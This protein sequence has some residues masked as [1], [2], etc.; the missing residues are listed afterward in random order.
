MPL[1][2]LNSPTNSLPAGADPVTVTPSGTAD[3]Y[4][5]WVEIT[6][7]APSDLFIAGIVFR[8]PTA[9]NITTYVDVQIGKGAAGSETVVATFGVYTRELFAIIP[10]PRLGQ[11]LAGAPISGIS[12]GDRIAARCRLKSTSVTTFQVAVLTL[13]NPITGTL[14][15]TANPLKVVPDG[16]SLSYTC[17]ATPWADSAWQQITASTAAAWIVNHLTCHSDAAGEV[18]IQLGTGASGS[19]TPVYTLRTRIDSLYDY[20]SLE[21]LPILFDNIASGARVAFRCRSS[22]ASHALDGIRVGYY[23][24]PL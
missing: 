21:N 8:D 16:S 18:E 5:S 17:S 1:E 6:S 20:P 7:S 4:G 24:L 15:T 11:V 2:H 19:E 9:G 10:T 12:S 23:E 22:T 3:T 13:P 14:E